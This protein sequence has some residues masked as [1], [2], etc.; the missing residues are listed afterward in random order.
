[1]EKNFK[2]YQIKYKGKISIPFAFFKIVFILL[3]EK[4]QIVH[5]HLFDASLIGLFAARICGIKKRIHTRHHSNSNKV[6][7]PQ[8]FKYDLFINKLSTGIVAISKN[9]ADVLRN[10]E[11]VPA[12]KIYIIYH[13]LDMNSIEKISNERIS[14]LRDKY[15]VEAKYPVIGVISRYIRLKGVQYIIPAL[16]KILEMHP[17]AY[18]ILANA[19]GNYSDEIKKMLTEIPSENYIEIEFEEDLFA[20]YKVFDFYVHVPIDNKCEAFGQTYV[21]A[22]A[23][24]IPSVFTLSGIANEFIINK[25]NAIVVDYKNS[26]QISN[27]LIELMHNNSLKSHTVQNGKESIKQFDIL[28]SIN[29]TEA[30]Y[31]N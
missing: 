13:G 1:M 7:S 14:K 17:N 15:K 10:D 8:G 11:Q 20:F 25:E 29:R 30:V 12:E 9:V 28:N 31:L 21:E 16:K 6:Y 26:E 24:G 23:S 27:A 5:T 19:N 3:K 22:L 18:L 4:P 2:T